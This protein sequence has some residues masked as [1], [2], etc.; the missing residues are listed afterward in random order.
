MSG[1]CMCGD[2]Y[3]P[4]CG[5]AQGVSPQEEA[6]VEW[7]TEY[8][9]RTFVDYEYEDAIRIELDTLIDWTYDILWD[10][11]HHQGYVKDE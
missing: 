10:F 8:I 7:I 9:R 1:P 4:S 5:P 2:I 11:C 6:I 3:C